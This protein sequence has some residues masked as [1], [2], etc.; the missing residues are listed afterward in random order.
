MSSK[1]NKLIQSDSKNHNLGEIFELIKGNLQS[2][3]VKSIQDA[4]YYFINK[5]K[6]KLAKNKFRTMHSIW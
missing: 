6:V 5:G 1:V 4:E 2:T 3:K